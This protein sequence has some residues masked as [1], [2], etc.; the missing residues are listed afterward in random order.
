MPKE[1]TTEVANIPVLAV[2]PAKAP[3]VDGNFAVIETYLRGWKNRVSSM[4][5]TEDNMEEVRVI[6]KEAVQYRNSLSKIQ[7]DIKKLYFND[8]KAVFDAKVNVLLAVIG[9][10]EQAADDVLAKE[11]KERVDG[12][13]E[14]LDHHKAKF[15]E[16]Y[17]LDAVRL[18]RVEYRKQFYNKTA[19]AGCSSMDKFQKEDLEAQFQVL[20]KDM[21]AVHA[22]IRLVKATCEGESRLNV[23]H[24]ISQLDRSD[25]ATVVEEI[26]AE[27]HRLRDLDRTPLPEPEDAGPED[28]ECAECKVADPRLGGSAPDADEDA[29]G[30]SAPVAL[31]VTRGID[32]SSDFKGRNKEL[33]IK[34]TYPCDLSDAL[35]E[36]FKRL[37]LHGIKAKVIEEVVF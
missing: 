34:I 15:Q 17:K 8:P 31:G 25:V 26:I 33:K 29:F 23:M 20:K 27:K 30:G 7:G 35:T 12:I 28:A 2:T 3:S 4:D 10:V 9:E 6:K 18:S 37:A 24:W 36:V 13:N 14:V 19:P 32:F 22:N 1:K 5:M 16:Q 11:E 21:D